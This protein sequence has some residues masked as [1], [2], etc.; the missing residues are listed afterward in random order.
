[1]KDMYVNYKDFRNGYNK[2][3]D[4]VKKLDTTRHTDPCCKSATTHAAQRARP[5]N[6]LCL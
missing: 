6:I 3:G 5:N 4:I 2:F 1:M